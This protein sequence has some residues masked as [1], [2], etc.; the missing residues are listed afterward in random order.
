MRN[1]QTFKVLKKTKINTTTKVETILCDKPI[2]DSM[3]R[4]LE[5]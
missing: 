4:W 3:E 2:F 1:Q 5:N